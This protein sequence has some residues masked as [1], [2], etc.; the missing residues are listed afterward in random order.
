MSN[1]RTAQHIVLAFVTVLLVA[2]AAIAGGRW[3]AWTPT[4]ACL[5]CA[6][7][8]PDATATPPASR[9]SAL[10]AGTS[11]TVPGGSRRRDSANAGSESSATI[12]RSNPADANASG[13][14]KPN[15][16]RS[17]W[18]PWGTTSGSFRG[19]TGNAS[20]PSSSLGGLWRLMSLVRPG[21]A[22]DGIGA[23]R[24]APASVV[25]H[26][27]P[28]ASGSKPAAPVPPA[29]ATPPPTSPA[30]EAPKPPAPAPAPTPAPTPA[31]SP[32]PAPAPAPPGTSTPTPPGGSAPPSA[33]DAP[34]TDPFHEN[35]TPPPD[36]FGGVPPTGPLDPGGTG[37]SGP[38]GLPGGDPSPTPEPS[39]ILLV[40]T[41][42]V[43]IMGA[44]RRRRLI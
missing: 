20:G 38:G 18:Q 14:S 4:D 41:G 19:Y 37:G 8:E 33:P 42:L 9:V 29:A 40:G 12:A 39:A 31:P 5:F 24:E 26:S 1:R 44:L 22:A 3:R 36:P 32:A 17:P 6:T 21:S 16:S 7:P 11:G 23:P 35:E 10:M 43:A 15:G 13:P 2:A 27:A 25:R 28:P 30:P 34:P